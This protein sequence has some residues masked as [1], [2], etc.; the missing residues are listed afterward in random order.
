MFFVLPCRVRQTGVSRAAPEANIALIAANVLFYLLGW[1]WVVG[2]GTG[3]LSVL[4]YAFSH[5]N[6]W[7]LL[8][9]MWALWVFGNP[10]NRR[11]G[12]GYYPVAYL[13]SVLLVG[14]FAR[15]VLSTPLV[16][17]SGAVFAVITLALV[18]MPAAVLEIAFVA[19]FPLSVVVGLLSKPRQ[20]FQ[21]L[22]R[23]AICPIPALWAL[24]LIPLM[25]L[26]LLCWFNW[27]PTYLAH[28]LGM[29]CGLGVV[30][31]LPKRITMG[32]RSVVGS[33]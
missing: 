31:L 20:W 23:W 17:S 9:N 3:L 5:A 18:L 22:V 26:V 12:N 13:A 27:C 8:A 32:G 11:I 16:G 25:Q 6:F 19:L 15:L 1:C 10:V 29:V 21:W 28:L 24:L 33:Y 4:L 7:H 30:V 14:I 2:P